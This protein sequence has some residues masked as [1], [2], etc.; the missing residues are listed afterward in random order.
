MGWFAICLAP[1][2][3]SGHPILRESIEHRALVHVDDEWVDVDI[4]LTFYEAPSR[5]ERRRMDT[6]G[7]ATIT[8]AECADYLADHQDRWQSALSMSVAGEPVELVTLHDPEI[9]L[10]ERH[11]LKGGR[12]RLRLTYFARLPEDRAD[13]L[14]IEWEDRLWPEVSRIHDL[15]VEAD[16]GFTVRVDESD[17]WS[18]KASP[19]G[20]PLHFRLLV[21]RAGGEPAPV[22]HD[23]APARA[24]EADPAEVIEGGAIN[25][26]ADPAGIWK[27][28]FALIAAVVAV[29]CHSDWGKG[30][31][32]RGNEQEI[33]R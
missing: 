26:H 27:Y 17:A 5:A 9:D 3:A 20:E 19:P 1:C 13:P 29:A 33:T 16:R 22:S 12:H 8:P 11:D 4:V 21:S 25:G 32:R 6:N 2:F 31:L 10:M 14:V 28:A 24:D 7:D 15:S 23:P 30:A 18:W